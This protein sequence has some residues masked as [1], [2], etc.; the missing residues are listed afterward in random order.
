[1]TVPLFEVVSSHV[2]EIHECFPTFIHILYISS[3]KQSAVT[4]KKRIFYVLQDP[5]KMLEVNRSL[6]LKNLMDLAEETLGFA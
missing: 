4:L 2:F 3:L 5:Y 6:R 1:M